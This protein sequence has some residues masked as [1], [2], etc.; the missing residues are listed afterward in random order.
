MIGDVIFMKINVNL[1]VIRMFFTIMAFY[2]LML[3]CF[4]WMPHSLQTMGA[5][6]NVKTVSIDNMRG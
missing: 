6:L 2:L 1:L 4:E 5:F 3:G